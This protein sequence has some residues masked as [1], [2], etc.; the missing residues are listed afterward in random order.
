MNFQNTIDLN[1]DDIYAHFYM[2]NILK[3][4]GDAS[5]AA[6]QFEKVIKLSPDYSW[7]YYNLAVIDFENGN[8]DDAVDKLEKTL[9]LNPKDQE[10]YIN[11]AKILAKQGMYDNASGVIERAVSAGVNSGDLFYLEA[12]IDKKLG[13]LEAFENGLRLALEHEDTLSVPTSVIQK[14]LDGLNAI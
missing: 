9:E 8:F 14:E 7:A 4:M 10:A 1:D 13:N 3:E 12:L 11:Y 2:G 5:S 6:E